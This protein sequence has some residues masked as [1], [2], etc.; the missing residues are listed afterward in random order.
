MKGL[1]TQNEKI[2]DEKQPFGRDDKNNVFSRKLWKILFL[3]NTQTQAGKVEGL[4]RHGK[5][6]PAFFQSYDICLT[7]CI[8]H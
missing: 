3:W 4:K 5:N 2:Q 6:T 7:L 1:S 8:V